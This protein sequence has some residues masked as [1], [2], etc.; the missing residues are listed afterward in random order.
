LV[1]FEHGPITFLSHLEFLAVTIG[2]IAEPSAEESKTGKKRVL[3]KKSLKE[4]S[5]TWLTL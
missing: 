2:G 4:R 1:G 5:K 3:E